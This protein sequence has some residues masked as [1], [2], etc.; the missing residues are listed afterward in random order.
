MKRYGRKAWVPKACPDCGKETEILNDKSDISALFQAHYC[1][2][3]AVLIRDEFWKVPQWF[4]ICG[5][6]AI[7]SAIY[8]PNPLLSL[9]SKL[10][11]TEPIPLRYEA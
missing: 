7:R 3:N 9:V 8:A 2:W 5:S 4:G 6:C 10:T 1:G 11:Y